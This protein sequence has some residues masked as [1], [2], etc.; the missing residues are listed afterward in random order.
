LQSADDTAGDCTCREEYEAADDH[1]RRAAKIGAAGEH[2]ET[3]RSDCKN[4]NRGGGG[5]GQE[6]LE[7]ANSYGN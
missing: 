4:C 1:T 5:A 6:N 2:Q 3:E 7:P